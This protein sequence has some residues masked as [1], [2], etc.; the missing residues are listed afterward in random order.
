[1][2]PHTGL[3]LLG[4]VA[5]QIRIRRRLNVNFQTAFIVSQFTLFFIIT[6][7]DTD[8]VFHFAWMN[9]QAATT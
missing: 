7:A 4:K 1:M 8:A 3:F 9:F 2:L 5:L 6:I